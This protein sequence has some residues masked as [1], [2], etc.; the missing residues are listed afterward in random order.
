MSGF[1][2]AAVILAAGIF[3]AWQAYKLY[4]DCSVKSAQQLMFG[5]F[6]YLPLV[7]LAITTGI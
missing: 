7:Q 6:I 5:G 3:F 1:V 4:R 2:S